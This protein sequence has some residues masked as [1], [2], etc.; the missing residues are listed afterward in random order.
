MFWM[1]C[2]H[3]FAKVFAGRA[4][5][6]YAVEFVGGAARKSSV[7]PRPDDKEIHILRIVL[8]EQFV[9]FD[10]AIEIFLIP[11]TGDV[12]RRHSYFIKP[13]SERLPFPECVIIGM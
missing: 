2:P 5:E 8:L 11:P 12:E 6:V 3:V 13:R 1:R 7:V 4:S 9:Y 10:R